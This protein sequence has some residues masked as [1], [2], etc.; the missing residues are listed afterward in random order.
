MAFV[1]KQIS[2][3]TIGI[4]HPGMFAVLLLNADPYDGPYH[5]LAGSHT[6]CFVT[7]LCILQ[8]K[9]KHLGGNCGW[10]LKEKVR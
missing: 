6:A 7:L 1:Q 2:T 5:C 8:D 9:N 3:Y 4:L 10:Q